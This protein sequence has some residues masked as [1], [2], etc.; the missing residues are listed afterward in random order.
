MLSDCIK[1]TSP[2]SVKTYLFFLLS[3]RS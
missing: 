3:G 2:V 1:A